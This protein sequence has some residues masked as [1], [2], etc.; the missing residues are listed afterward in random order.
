LTTY[1]LFDYIL[2]GWCNKFT[3]N[4]EP[5]YKF[6]KV[7]QMVNDELNGNFQPKVLPTEM[8][9]DDLKIFMDRLFGPPFFGKAG[10][11]A[12]RDSLGWSGTPDRYWEARGRALDQ[13]LIE[14]GRGKGGSVKLI[15]TE[16][17]NPTRDQDSPLPAEPQE[18]ASAKEI[19]LYE[20]ARGVIQDSWA[21][22]ENYDDHV[23]SITALRGRAYTG[24]KWTRPDISLLSVK[25]YPYL[26]QRY[27]DIVTFE[28]KPAGQTTV[29]GIFEALSHQQ[30]AT[31]AYAVFHVPDLPTDKIFQEHITD[32]QRILSTAR[33]HGIGV[34]IAT[35]ISDWETWDEILV[36]ERVVPDPEQANRFIATGFPQDI[37][38]Q[39]I[40][41]HK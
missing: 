40:K 6:S 16:K 26:P 15:A 8:L 37:R 35:D 4:S 29:E 23:V 18:L 22:D 17:I 32:A 38:D 20:P 10:N 7:T 31:R 3:P 5:Q 19:D 11:K 30:F 28:V 14:P 33:K 13:G 1:G 39:I 24:G 9:N 41:W 12:I 34:I 27:F 2:A 25:A 36:A 21:K